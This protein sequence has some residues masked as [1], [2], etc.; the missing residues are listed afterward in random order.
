MENLESEKVDPSTEISV[1]EAG[2]RG[3]NVTLARHG[4][5]FYQK[6]GKSGGCRTKALYSEFFK[7]FGKKGGR[8][9]R[10]AL[11]DSTGE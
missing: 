9:R 5:E 6:I 1:R 2:R 10:P 4:R 8:P 11:N 3:G 7:E